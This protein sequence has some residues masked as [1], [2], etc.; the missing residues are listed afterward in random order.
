MR[1]RIIG[2]IL[3]HRLQGV[4]G[5][6]GLAATK[7]D[8][9]LV[10]LGVG[11]I[12]LRLHD[13]VIQLTG[14]V[15]PV[16]QNQKLNVILLD[17][18]VLGMVLIQRA[19]F[20]GGFVELVVSKIKVTQHAVAYGIIREILLRLAQEFLGLTRL[21]LGH[22]Q[23]GKR[24]PGVRVVRCGVNRPPERLLGVGKS[25]ASLIEIPQRDQRIGG[26]GIQFHR[27]LEI[28]LRRVPLLPV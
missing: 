24:E 9:A 10:N 5:V 14:I 22:V 8:L 26:L 3:Q 21:V 25:P 18:H 12:G 28:H 13:F 23:G 4:D 15:E 1:Y 27:L 16:F 20:G 2:I 7:L 11:V 17:H 19:V 6:V